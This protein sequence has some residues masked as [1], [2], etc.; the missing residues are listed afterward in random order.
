MTLLLF[1]LIFSLLNWEMGFGYFCI[2]AAVAERGDSINLCDFFTVNL[3]C[4]IR[5]W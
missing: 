3:D 2:Q 1:F 4:Y 5:G